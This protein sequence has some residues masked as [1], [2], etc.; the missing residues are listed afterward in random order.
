MYVLGSSCTD[1]QL[2]TT[3]QAVQIVIPDPN[4]KGSYCIDE[5]ALKT[6]FEY[7]DVANTPVAI[8]SLAG[9]FRKGKSFMLNLFLHYLWAGK[10]HKVQSFISEESLFVLLFT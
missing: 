9:V 8:Y 10:T 7:P 2:E 5:E 4:R 6:I 1:R 3:Y